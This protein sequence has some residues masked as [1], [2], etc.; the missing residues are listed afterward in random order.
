MTKALRRKGLAY[1]SDVLYSNKWTLGPDPRLPEASRSRKLEIPE[2]KPKED[3][4]QDHEEAEEINKKRIEI[5]NEDSPN[6]TASANSTSIDAGVSSKSILMLSIAQQ[7][8]PAQA[9]QQDVRT[10]LW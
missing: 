7:V 1:L 2:A 4:I 3:K 9:E 5:E 8:L 6:S 10:I